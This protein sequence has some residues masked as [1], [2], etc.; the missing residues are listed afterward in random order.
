MSEVP[1]CVCVRACVCVCVCVYVCVCV[2]VCVCVTSHPTPGRGAGAG[3]T[4]SDL[5]LRPPVA[6][7]MRGSALLFSC[8]SLQP[9]DKRSATN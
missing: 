6:L 2:C 8:I 5:P 9:L 3:G 4:R 1:L 7:L